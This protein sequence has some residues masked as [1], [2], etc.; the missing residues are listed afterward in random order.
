[1]NELKDEREAR[2]E[3]D[4]QLVDEM[5]K[6][7]NQG[8][9]AGRAKGYEKGYADGYDDGPREGLEDNPDHHAS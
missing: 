2:V 5:I 8:V 3:M 4:A 9:A 1:M 6:A 7:F